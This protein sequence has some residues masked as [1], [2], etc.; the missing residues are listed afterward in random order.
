MIKI[1]GE[2]DEFKAV[3]EYYNKYLEQR[4]ESFIKGCSE[5]IRKERLK[6]FDEYYE[7]RDRE[8]I[9]LQKKA[10]EDF[11]KNGF[12]QDDPVLKQR[13]IESMKLA[14]SIDE[15]P[16]VS[17]IIEAKMDKF[18]AECEKKWPSLYEK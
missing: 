2:N 18:I 17:E 13:Q 8:F 3:K 16:T 7:K 11:K 14:E 1:N 15:H 12:T 6:I 9:E 4:R 10:Y 5:E